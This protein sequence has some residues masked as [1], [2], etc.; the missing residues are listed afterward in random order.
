MKPDNDVTHLVT[1][2][3]C[4]KLLVFVVSLAVATLIPRKHR[5]AQNVRLFVSSHPCM[6]W[7][8]FLTSLISSS[9]SSSLPHSSSTSSSSCYPSTSSRF[10]GKIPCATSPRRWGQLTSSCSHTKR[11]IPYHQVPHSYWA[12][13]WQKYLWIDM[14]RSTKIFCCSKYGERI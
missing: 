5:M 3:M 2:W 4:V 13:S 8:F 1:T 14:T 9:P 7:A 11:I 12:W 6:N 10:R